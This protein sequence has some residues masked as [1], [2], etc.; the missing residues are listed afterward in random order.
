MTNSTPRGWDTIEADTDTDTDTTF[1]VV[2]TSGGS[3][4]HG[5]DEAAAD[6]AW[7]R[8]RADIDHD[9]CLEPVRLTYRIDGRVIDTYDSISYAEE[10]RR[11]PDMVR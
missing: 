9:E 6:L 3:I 8:R 7:D 11:N 10:L 4:Y 2:S 1:Q 5:T